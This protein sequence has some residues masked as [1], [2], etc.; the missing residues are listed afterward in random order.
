MNG[1]GALPLLFT[2]KQIFKEVQTFVDSLVDEVC[3]GGYILQYPN[4]DPNTR[5]SLVYS[6]LDKRPN[7]L[8]FA[9][10]VKINLPRGVDKRCQYDWTSLGLPPRKN[11]FEWKPWLVLPGLEQY[12][13]K[14]S[15]DAK[16]AIVVAIEDEEPPDFNKLLS[17]YIALK[18]R[19]TIELITPTFPAQSSVRNTLRTLPW[20]FKWEVAWIEC[21]SRKATAGL[22]D[23]DINWGTS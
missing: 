20:Y 21:L 6:L 23:G 9:K 2:N 12:L 1:I 4:E 17:L 14:F 18:G 16:L 7:L 10:N 15:A 11:S 3:I 22:K 8:A 19:P 13:Q 5:W